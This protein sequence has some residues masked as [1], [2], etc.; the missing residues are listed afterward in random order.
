MIFKEGKYI[1]MEDR[2][3][4]FIQRPLLF[5]I[6]ILPSV[7]ITLLRERLTIPLSQPIEAARETTGNSKLLR[8]EFFFFLSSATATANGGH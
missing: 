1:S 6:K 2:E 5:K 8:L 3:G 7:H 4:S